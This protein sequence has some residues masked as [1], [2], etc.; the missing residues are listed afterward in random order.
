MLVRV[1]RILRIANFKTKDGMSRTPG[2]T[3]DRKT[4]EARRRQIA[5]YRACGLSAAIRSPSFI[6]RR[7]RGEAE[8]AE[9]GMKMGQ[10]VSIVRSRR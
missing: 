2:E 1:S 9:L 6:S 8:S 3:R 10:A 4:D 7:Q 5:R